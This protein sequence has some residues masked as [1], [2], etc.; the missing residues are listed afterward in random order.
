MIYV[1]HGADELSRTEYLATLRAP[2]GDPQFADLNTTRFDGRKLSVSELQHACDAVPFL[3]DQRLVLVDGMLARFDPRRT[4]SEDA[5]E[6][7]QEGNPDLAKDLAAYLERVPDTTLLVFLESKSLAKNN[8]ILKK[9][10]AEKKLATVKEFSAPD[11]KALPAWIVKRVESKHAKIDGN[12][13]SEL[14]EHVGEDLR[15]LDTEI[16][17]LLTYRANE[18]IRI[19]D[20]RALVASVREA[21]VFGL[22]NAIARR[23]RR[24]ALILLHE[25]LDQG[26]VPHQLLPT[27][28][29]QFRLL[30]QM[31]DLAARG[32]TLAQATEK[33][34]AN[35]YPAQRAWNTATN[36]SLPQLEATYQKLLETDIAIKTGKSEPVL[37]L[38]LLVTE[39]TR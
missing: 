7:E 4:K 10:T 37:A 16:E 36:F 19:D 38:D 28:T 1:L 8:S 14:A 34:H 32:L 23:D 2:L 18:V 31:K 6:I 20:V 26:A 5:S 35:P 25:Q 11:A 33:I 13:A 15:L 3:T 21:D 9:L 27:I 30:L 12:A 39:L 24:S 17:K 22:V 29:W